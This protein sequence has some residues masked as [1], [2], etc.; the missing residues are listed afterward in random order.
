MGENLETKRIKTGIALSAVISAVAACIPC[1]MPLVAP[2]V[3]W[4]GVSG[5]AMVETGK[6]VEIGAVSAFILGALLLLRARRRAR[7]TQ[8]CSSNGSCGCRNGI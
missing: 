2:L 3:A 5:I 4:L 6:Y 1:C 8:A 7:I